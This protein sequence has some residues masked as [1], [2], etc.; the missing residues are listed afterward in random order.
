MMPWTTPPRTTPPWTTPSRA[1]LS[2]V[3]VAAVAG[4]LLGTV[5]SADLAVRAAG[6]GH[7]VRREGSGNPGAANAAAVLGA[8]WGAAVLV[9]D[10]AKG[11]AAGFGG[12]A[13]GGDRGAYVAA[14]A[15]IAGHVLPV[16]NG[17]RGGKG[18]ATSAGAT[19]AVFPAYFPV[20]LGV[21]VI[22]ALRH[23]RAEQAT[24]LACAGWVAASLA[25]WALDLPNGWGPAP[26]PGLVGFS[27]AGAVLVLAAFRRGR[28]AGQASP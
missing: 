17:G 5:P 25:A 23:R 27:G 16:W 13:I 12:R 10:M 21:T 6:G 8:R 26:S 15:S 9:A 3:T 11:A 7:D 18:V 14:T 2:R 4:Y 24:A 1:G 22:G 20:D 28:G 19:L